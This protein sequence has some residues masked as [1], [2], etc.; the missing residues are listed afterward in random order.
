MRPSSFAPLARIVLLA[1]LVTIVAISPA[2][3]GESRSAAVRLSFLQ[4]TDRCQPTATV[5][6]TGYRVH[7][8]RVIYYREGHSG[9]EAAWF[10]TPQFAD[11]RA[12]SSGTLTSVADVAAPPGSGWWVHAILRSVG[13]ARLA[14]VSSPVAYAPNSCPFPIRSARLRPR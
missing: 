10:N 13:G 11:D 6:W 12:R 2:E 5:T 3:A 4:A 14:E 8:V 7:H 9:D 1:C